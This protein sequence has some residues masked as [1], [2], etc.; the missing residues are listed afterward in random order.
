M[1]VDTQPMS[2]YRGQLVVGTLDKPASTTYSPASNVTADDQQALNT[3][4]E[5]AARTT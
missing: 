4:D 1:A 3:P 2:A 5:L